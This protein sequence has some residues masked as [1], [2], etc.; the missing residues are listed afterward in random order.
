M[1]IFA[2]IFEGWECGVVKGAVLDF[3]L[4]LIYLA[5]T[6]ACDVLLLDSGLY[7]FSNYTS[8]YRGAVWSAAIVWIIVSTVRLWFYAS[9]PIHARSCLF[10]GSCQSMRSFVKNIFSNPTRSKKP[11][12]FVSLLVFV[13]FTCLPTI[14][15]SLMADEVLCDPNVVQGYN[16]TVWQSTESKRIAT[17]TL[18][19]A[20]AAIPGSLV[21]IP[22]CFSILF[23]FAI[24]CVDDDD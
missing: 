20:Q 13:I 3:T 23:V 14:F 24:C 1:A 16:C 5:L 2:L 8:I 7:S 4:A 21:M 19:I 9:K 18:L 22:V 11:I 15:S 12:Y 10:E 6:I 17:G